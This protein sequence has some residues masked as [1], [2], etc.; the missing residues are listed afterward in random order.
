MKNI[1]ILL[2]LINITFG[3]NIG[4]VGNSITHC[5]YDSYII[6]KLPDCTTTKYSIPGIAV[7]VANK[8]YKDTSQFQAVLNRKPEYI[9][10]MLGSNDWNAYFNKNEAWKDYW[11][12][13][14]RYL[15]SKLKRK[16]AVVLG[17]ITYRIGSDNANLAID[18]MNSRIRE[19]ANS[20]HLKVADFNSTLGLNTDYFNEDGIHPNDGGLWK[21]SQT[22]YYTLKKLMDPPTLEIDDEYWNEVEDY[23]EQRK[24]GWFG[25]QP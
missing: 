20:Y 11:E 19:V 4:F 9:V 12:S 8:Q 2:T 17:T 15:I 3:Q 23:E 13:E 6:E 14:Y 22:A 16:S 18:G 7:A 24:S 5:G 1:L 10:V 25:C 21:L